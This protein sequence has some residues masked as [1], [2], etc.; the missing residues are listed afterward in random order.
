MLKADSLQVPV[1][2]NKLTVQTER[3]MS[4]NQAPK[5]SIVNSVLG[6]FDGRGFLGGGQTSQQDSQ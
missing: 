3:R 5:Q 1:I 6:F 4:T 2:S